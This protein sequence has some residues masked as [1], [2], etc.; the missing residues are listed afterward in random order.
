MHRPNILWI[1]TDEQR[2]DSIGC[3]GSKWAKTPCLDALAEGGVVFRQAYCNSPVCVPSRTSQLF[4]RYPQEVATVFNR[5]HPIPSEVTREMVSLLRPFQDAGYIAASF[6]KHHTSVDPGWDVKEEI[7]LDARYAGY[8][9]LNPAY[10]EAAHHVIKRPGCTPII[11]AG[12]Y[13][14]SHE[15]PSRA[16]T[17]AAIRFLS[18]RDKDRP[19]F[20]RASHN[21]PH[22][23]VLPPP[24]FDAM[25]HPDELP[26][27]HYDD[28]AYRTRSAWDRAMADRH[29]MSELTPEQTRQI[30]KDYMG[31]CSYVDSETGR[32]LAAVQAMG[33][34]DDTIVVFSSDHGK[35]MGEWGATEKGAFDETCWRVP[36][37]W[38]WPGQLP[39]G[40]VRNDLCELVDLGATL[41]ELTGLSA[42]RP[43]N[44]RGRNLF[45]DSSPEAVFSQ[46]GYPDFRAPLCNGLDFQD[47]FKLLRNAV[48]TDRWQLDATWLRDGEA[49]ADRDGNL[50]D[51]Q[52][53][54]HETR[55][56]WTDPACAKIKDGLLQRIDSW[57]QSLDRP[58]ALFGS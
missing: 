25:Y 30:W 54:P 7:L 43:G 55:N 5:S 47:Y 56:L 2:A 26:I 14:S 4:C 28:A 37:I 42:R 27:R 6:G 58:A 10:D 50:F 16:T 32:L 36:M 23:P 41:L 40:E 49:P 20:L 39:R 22:T 8:F 48:R 29:R 13:P 45:G 9:G 11:L 52:N 21:Y 24:P 33:L 34:A 3:D 51:K 18:A 53:D 1:Q 46:I 15:D 57:F 31:L 17:D 44:W 38:S 19:F 12:T 35:M